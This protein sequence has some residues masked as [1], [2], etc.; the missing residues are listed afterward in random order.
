MREAPHCSIPSY[1]GPENQCEGNVNTIV[2]L[3]PQLIVMISGIWIPKDALNV[4][5]VLCKVALV[6]LVRWVGSNGFPCCIVINIL[7][8]AH[9]LQYRWYLTYSHLSSNLRKLIYNQ[10]LYFWMVQHC[11]GHATKIQVLGSWHV[12]M[13]IM[14]SWGYVIILWDLPSWFPTTKSTATKKIL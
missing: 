2:P 3:L 5:I 10:S 7:R 14:A 12:L 8:S 1:D 13:T 6:N 11:H 4:F 9:A